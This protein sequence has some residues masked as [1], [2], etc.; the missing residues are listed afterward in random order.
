MDWGE[1]PLVATERTR[2]RAESLKVGLVR[3]CEL[4]ENDSSGKREVYIES[5]KR[6][7]ACWSTTSMV[8]V[9]VVCG[10]RWLMVDAD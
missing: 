6:M 5:R 7:S 8:A 3:M 9:C 4:G 1:Q 10:V 2:V